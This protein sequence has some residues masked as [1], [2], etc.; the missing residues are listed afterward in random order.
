MQHALLVWG[1]YIIE[2]MS[3]AVFTATS[4]PCSVTCVFLIRLIMSLATIKSRNGLKVTQLIHCRL[5]CFMF[6]QYQASKR[7]MFMP[8][9]SL[10]T[11]HPTALGLHLTLHIPTV[12]NPEVCKTPR[13][14]SMEPPASCKN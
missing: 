9:I 3:V 13:H 6:H 10:E 11:I 8:P 5:A 2:S 1:N 12:S 14:H 7:I 4:K